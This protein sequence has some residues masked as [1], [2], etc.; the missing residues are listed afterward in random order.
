MS[1][2]TAF[3]LTH[4]PSEDRPWADDLEVCAG[5]DKLHGF[6]TYSGTIPVGEEDCGELN[7]PYAELIESI[8]PTTDG[9]DS[10]TYIEVRTLPGCD[11]FAPALAPKVA[12]AIALLGAC[13]EH[14]R[15]L[16]TDEQV[17]AFADAI[18]DQARDILGINNEKN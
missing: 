11:G 9:R 12:A 7:Y 3:V 17:R 6:R 5:D 2:S 4:N 10:E 16:P 1:N 18:A 14:G 8:V 13:W 15:P